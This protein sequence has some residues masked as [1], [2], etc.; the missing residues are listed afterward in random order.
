MPKLPRI[1]GKQ[2]LKALEK[3]GFLVFRV[4]GSHHFMKHSDG[5][6]TVVPIHSGEI[7]INLQPAIYSLLLTK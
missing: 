7:I 6:C 5:R 4:K 2:L 3:S 1:K